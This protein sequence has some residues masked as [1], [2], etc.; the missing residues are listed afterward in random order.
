MRKTVYVVPRAGQWSVTRG[1]GEAARDYSTQR[2][3]I[4][5]ARAMAKADHSGQLVVYRRDGR[6]REHATYGMPPIQDPPGRKSARIE[7]VVGQITRA[8]LGADPLPLRD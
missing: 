8:S 4:E 7:K 2:E 6:V 5:H 3:A 1:D